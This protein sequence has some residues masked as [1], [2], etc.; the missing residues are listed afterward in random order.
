MLIYSFKDGLVIHCR[1]KRLHSPEIS[2]TEWAVFYSSSSVIE[3][4]WKFSASRSFQWQ[5]A[6]VEL[7]GDEGN[8]IDIIRPMCGWL[9]QTCTS[10]VTDLFVTWSSHM[11]LSVRAHHFAEQP[12]NIQFPVAISYLGTCAQTGSL[13]IQTWVPLFCPYVG[14]CI[15]AHVLCHSVVGGLS[16]L[17]HSPVGHVQHMEFIELHALFTL[18]QHQLSAT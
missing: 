9:C 2:D 8:D 17:N 11:F 4:A 6:G 18:I 10:S 13:A 3:W 16:K 5:G 15:Q 7:T 12:K 14:H 1:G